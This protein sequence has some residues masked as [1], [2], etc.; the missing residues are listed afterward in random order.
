[1]GRYVNKDVS[2]EDIFNIDLCIFFSGCCLNQYDPDGYSTGFDC[3]TQKKTSDKSCKVK[4]PNKSCNE[5]V[6]RVKKHIEV[7]SKN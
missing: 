5:D 2:H 6:E 1:M 4:D 3:F 7:R